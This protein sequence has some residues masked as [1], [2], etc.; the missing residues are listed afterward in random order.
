MSKVLDEL[1]TGVTSAILAAEHPSDPTY[2]PA[3]LS[4][5][6]AWLEVAEHE[7]AIVRE[8]APDDVDNARGRELAQRGAVRACM[9]A[10]DFEGARALA[11]AYSEGE[12]G[13][14]KHRDMLA[15]LLQRAEE[16]R[17]P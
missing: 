9:H 7:E 1:K 17:A 6:E 3:G 2:N 12:P 11:R 14:P 10:G 8:I 4:E 16:G 5:R 15:D 13:S